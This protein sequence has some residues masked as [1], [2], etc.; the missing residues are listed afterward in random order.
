MAVLMLQKPDGRTE[1]YPFR[2]DRLSIG[3][4]SDNDLV[5]ESPFLSRYHAVLV[6]SSEGTSIQDLGSK[7]GTWVNRIRLENAARILAHGDQIVLGHAQ[8]TVHYY[9]DDATVTSIPSSS[10]VHGLEV[11]MA[12]R[13]VSIQGQRLS[14]P[15]TR[16]EFDL[17]SLLWERRGAACS[18]DELAAQGWPERESGD[19]SDSEIEQY[20]RR[21]R[22]RLDDTGK[23]SQVITTI[24]RYGYK[25]E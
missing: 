20:I 14:P 5:I 6:T 10:A 24:R 25:I 12:G 7:N 21:L 23:D 8:V 1:P 17:L 19:V 22:R 11:D 9:T 18:R 3:R 13:E 4:A 16:K 15:L 2:S